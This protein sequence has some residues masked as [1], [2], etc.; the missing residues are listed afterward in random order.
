MLVLV[1]SKIDEIRKQIKGP[2]L[3]LIFNK[4][5]TFQHGFITRV[6]IASLYDDQDIEGITLLVKRLNKDKA[7]G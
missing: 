5:D 4:I 6:E 2:M 1:E 7:N 3:R